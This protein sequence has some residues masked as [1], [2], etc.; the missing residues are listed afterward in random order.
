MTFL[1]VEA[2]ERQ[3][4]HFT[5][6]RVIPQGLLAVPNSPAYTYKDDWKRLTDRAR[7]MDLEVGK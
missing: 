4:R 3:H 1:V 6:V 2:A 5:E 7:P